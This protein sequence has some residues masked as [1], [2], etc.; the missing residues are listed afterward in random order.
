MSTALAKELPRHLC[1]YVNEEDAIQVVGALKAYG[2]RAYVA[3][4]LGGTIPDDRYGEEFRGEPWSWTV[5]VCR[6]SDFERARSFKQGL[7]AALAIKAAPEAF[8]DGVAAAAQIMRRKR[9]SARMPLATSTQ[10]AR[11]RGE[12]AH[13]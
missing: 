1:W 9:E 4:C 8:L 11:V 6:A 13:G 10:C 7:Y 5:W 3:P 2:I 12:S